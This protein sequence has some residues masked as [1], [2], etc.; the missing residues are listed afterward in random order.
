MAAP[1]VEMISVV[2]RVVKF[3]V[4][5]STSEMRGLPFV[6]IAAN[7]YSFVGPSASMIPGNI[8]SRE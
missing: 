5:D 8:I 7:L 6:A 2:G 3:R 1:V 4:K